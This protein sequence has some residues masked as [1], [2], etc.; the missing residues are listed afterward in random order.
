MKK[1]KQLYRS[2]DVIVIGAGPG[3]LGVAATLEGWHPFTKDSLSFLPEY[4]SREVKIFSSDLL[5]FDT[6]FL[7]RNGVR[8]I[9]FYRNLHHPTNHS[10]NPS[11]YRLKF[12]K[13]DP[14][15]WMMI[16][17][18]EPG[19]LWNNVPT[20]QLTLGPA[21]WME[22]A[23]YPIQQFFQD[24]GINKD[25][26]DLAHKNDLV[27]YYQKFVEYLGM[28]KKIIAKS[29]VR[30]ISKGKDRRRFRLVVDSSI[31]SNIYEC[32][33]IV[34]SVGPKSK[35]RKFNWQ[36]NELDYISS[37]FT[38]ASDYSGENVLVVGGGRSSDWAVTELFKAGKKVEYVMRQDS[39]NHLRLVK[40]SLNLPYYD[41]LYDIIQKDNKKLTIHYNSE[42]SDAFPGGKVS[43]INNK[44]QLETKFYLDHLI[45][46]I[47]S[48]VAYELLDEWGPIKFVEKRD[49]YRFQLNQ[50]SC[51]QSTFESSDI[52][53]LYPSGYLAQGTGLS[54]IGFHAG[55]YLISGDIYRK[56]NKLS[57]EE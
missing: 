52:K 8:P 46:E 56:I 5:S 31:S 29:K 43:V 17:I 16:S 35:E 48:S 14:V 32:D 7:M 51:D 4:V 40:D 6:R 13:T 9:E 20:N 1:T 47:G 22:L 10:L 12:F 36:K 38:C 27:N 57:T 33:Y 15:D 26:N 44:S 19:G 30:S 24:N 55:S 2:C 18:D 42:I 49:N 50:M 21:Y 54:V 34:F 41:F 39:D 53:N 23:H 25:P 28:S 11:E 3:G 45:I 37:Q